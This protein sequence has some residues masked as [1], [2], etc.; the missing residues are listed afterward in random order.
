[1]ERL[2]EMNQNYMT[3][4]DYEQVLTSVQDNMMKMRGGAQ[5]RASISGGGNIVDQEESK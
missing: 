3:L 2:I 1:M 4:L 5:L